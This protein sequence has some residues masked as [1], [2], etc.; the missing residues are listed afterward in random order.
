VDYQPETYIDLPL[1]SWDASWRL[2]KGSRIRIDVTSSDFPQYAAH[3][4][5]KDLW[6]VVRVRGE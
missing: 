6:C 3:P 4:N 5:K 2:E 1:E